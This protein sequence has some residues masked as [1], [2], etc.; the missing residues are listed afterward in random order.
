M[1]DE[2]DNETSET[3]APDTE[4]PQAEAEAPETQAS[5]ETQAQE[6]A[7]VE[8]PVAESAPAAVQAPVEEAAPE[9]E[10]SVEPEAAAPP[11]QEPAEQLSPKERRR[12][13]RSTHAG[14]ARKPRS[15]AE[16][17]TERLAERKD[18][19]L[20]RR[21]RRVAE[22]A[23]AAERRASAPA[24]EPLAPVHAPVEGKRKVRQGIVVSDKA[25]K[26]I[27]VRVDFARRHRRYEKI[28]RSSATLH[29]H[30]EN[31]DA[32]EGDTVRVVESRPLSRTK[33]WRLLDVLERAR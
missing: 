9:A 15:A 28:V 20:R 29:A 8:E 1:A 30:D 3:K 5:D 27:T 10:P 24:A 11:P 13:A 17:H 22:R 2:T 32:H 21:T 16:R 7:P 23:K 33:R 6:E 14:E 19:A 26:T 25:D 12:K 31:N 18:K 4:T